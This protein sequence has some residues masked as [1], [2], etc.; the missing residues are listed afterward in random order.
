MHWLET[1]LCL[2]AILLVVTIPVYTEVYHEVKNAAISD[3]ELSIENG[4][5]QLQNDMNALYT[6]P[7]ALKT[8]KEYNTLLNLSGEP[9][10]SDYPNLVLLQKDYR[11]MLISSSLC[12]N[13]FVFFSSNDVV[14]S[15]YGLFYNM[16]VFYN[17]TFEFEGLS[18]DDMRR[19]LFSDKYYGEF[20][21]GLKFRDI[22]K[23]RDYSM[24]FA[25]TVSD[26]GNNK[27]VMLSVYDTAKIM[28]LLGL[29][30]IEENGRVELLNN[31]NE[32]II[33]VNNME[34]GGGAE[35][36]ISKETSSGN[37][38]ADVTISKEFYSNRLSKTINMLLI[39]AALFLLLGL[40]MSV[41]FA[42]KNGR[43]VKNL[44]KFLTGS[45]AGQGKNEYDFIR[46]Y[47][48]NLKD[49]FSQTEEYVLD[50][51]MFKLLFS[52]LDAD[53]TDRYIRLSD[54]KFIEGAMLMVKS[55]TI[56]WE[57][58][59]NAKLD[60]KFGSEYKIMPIDPYTEVA[61]IN[62][63]QADKEWL[64]KTAC[65]LMKEDNIGI[66]GVMSTRFDFLKKSADVFERLCEL[67]R[68]AEPFM[69]LTFDVNKPIRSGKNYMKDYFAESKLLH[70][71]LK[72]GNSFEANR[73]IYKQWYALGTDV[74][75]D[76]D[77]ANLFYYQ[78]GV[79]NGIVI[80]TGFPEPLPMFSGKN[81]ITE[82]AFVVTRYIENLC[83]YMNNGRDD[84]QTDIEI[85]KFINDHYQEPL[86]YLTDVSE[87]FGLTAKVI[88]NTVKKLTGYTFSIYLKKLRLNHV[89]QLLKYTKTPIKDI[90]AQS[91]FDSSN[92]ML[93]SFK[94]EFGV[95][96]TEYRKSNQ[97][98]E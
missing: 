6:M 17:N 1:Y 76:D 96:P 83:D 86:F 87:E 48:L 77:I 70:E 85:V 50:N 19:L 16:D 97:K 82:N 47:V 75:T 7:D 5:N 15:K 36:N 84:K 66:K 91:G 89:V 20:L 30:Q 12:E 53:E 13:V 56:N 62:E 32:K 71:M 60:E 88:T 92:T 69:I 10:T 98:T 93:K 21:S 27:A 41:F 58:I 3:T 79:I 39:Y 90:A 29:N 54:G 14:L 68:Y 11:N 72:S 28:S 45:E 25:Y 37:I 2:V 51:M 80:D 81:G 57:Q 73:L 43:P 52:D 18:Y 74:G 46:D 4:L 40:I 33:T 34:N 44:V 67:I 94:K 59:F 26:S 24:I 38:K 42:Y 49:N 63:G 64:N 31:K 23:K 55:D 95:S 78:I 22:S 35:P 65:E 8:I 61:L 9:E